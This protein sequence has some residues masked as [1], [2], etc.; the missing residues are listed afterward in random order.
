MSV[1]EIRQKV[2]SLVDK[3]ENEAKLEK[4]LS[5]LSTDTEK[6]LDIEE[7][8]NWAKENYGNTLRKLAE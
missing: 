6:K 8:Y 4:V 2:H 7:F 1:D 5:I 3:K